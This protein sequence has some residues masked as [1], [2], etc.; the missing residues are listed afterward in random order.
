M[1]E[2][3]ISIQGLNKTF[4]GAKRSVVAP[5]EVLRD[6]DLSIPQGDI[7]GI[8]GFSGA[9]KSTLLRCLNRLEEPESGSVR[10]G[11]HD[12]CSLSHEQLLVFRRKI[13]MIFQ[14]FNLLEARTVV[15]NVSFPLE[16]A[17]QRSAERRARVDEILELVG[18]TDR[19]DFY[20][21]QLSGGQKQRVGIARALANEPIVLLSDEATS[22]LDPQIALNVLDLL[23]N[24]NQRL[25]LTIVLVTHQIEVIKYACRNVAVLENGRIVERGSVREVLTNPTSETMKVFMQVNSEM[26]SGGWKEGAGI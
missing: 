10:I 19:R 1:S 13:G 6:I 5:V 18:L 24:I 26:T 11:E 25:G 21:G 9:G 17:G 22:A 23:I 20:P 14:Q 4:W 8:M 15:G 7:F 3:F 16:V 2:P 12:V